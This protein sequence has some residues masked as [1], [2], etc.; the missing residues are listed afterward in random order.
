[1]LPLNLQH[2]P[3]R[4]KYHVVVTCDLSVYTQWQT[5]V[6]YYWYKKMKEQYPDSAMGGFT[7]LIHS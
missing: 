5:R 4:N 1:V 6:H 3:R 7:R 2:D